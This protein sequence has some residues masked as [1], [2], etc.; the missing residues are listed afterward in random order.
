VKVK[1]IPA[2][3]GVTGTISQS[4]RQYMSKITG[5]HEAKELHTENSHIGHCTHTAGS[6][7]VKVQNIFHGQHN[8]TCST[9]CK[10]R[11]AAALCTL[12]TWFV[13]GM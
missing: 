13:S 3:R 6:A 12:E 1:E 11:T 7:N 2:I 10:Y 8:I 9:N 4:L 5:R